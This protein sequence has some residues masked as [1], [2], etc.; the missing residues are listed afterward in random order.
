M[1]DRWIQPSDIGGKPNGF[2]LDGAPGAVFRRL[3]GG[4][5]LI[6]VLQ[7]LGK[8][9]ELPLEA[10]PKSRV[11]IEPLRLEKHLVGAGHLVAARL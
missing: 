9:L 10:V 8:P 1:P 6:P 11:V 7:A 3:S 2:G 4:E 5:F